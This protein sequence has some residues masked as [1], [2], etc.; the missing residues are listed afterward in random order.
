MREWEKMDSLLNCTS[1]I[2]LGVGST[3]FLHCNL[4][5]EII[6]ILKDNV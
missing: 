3:K 5:T 1:S 4:R 2:A 6:Q